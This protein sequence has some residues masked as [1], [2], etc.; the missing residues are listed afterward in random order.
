MG[1][2]LQQSIG[3]V[4]VGNYI[5]GGTANTS[6]GIHFA[7]NM[8]L[9]IG[10]NATKQG[11]VILGETEFCFLTEFILRAEEVFIIIPFPGKC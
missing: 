2:F 6:K 7:S 4:L 10:N 5:L 8:G 9:N 3:G 1:L 11:N